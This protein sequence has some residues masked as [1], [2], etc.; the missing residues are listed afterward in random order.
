MLGRL[1]QAVL[2]LLRQL[3]VM[4]APQ[5]ETPAN[6]DVAVSDPPPGMVLLQ[7]T[8]TPPSYFEAPVDLVRPDYRMT[9]G[10]GTAEATIDETTYDAAMRKGVHAELEARFLSVQMRTYRPFELSNSVVVREG[11]RREFF[12]EPAS[13]KL[14]MVAM[15]GN[16]DVLAFDDATGKTIIDR[17]EQRLR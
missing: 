10:S 3:R 6:T 16:L 8:F 15:Q 14:L 9:I 12:L 17:E 1:W 4:D 7:W 11:G 13:G 2:R 5:P